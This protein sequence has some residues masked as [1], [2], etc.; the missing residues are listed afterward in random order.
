VHH[1]S[2]RLLP[3]LAALALTL[4]ACDD[5]AGAAARAAAQARADS[6]RTAATDGG[7]AVDSALPIPE[8]L[9]RLKAA[10]A[11]STD[12][13]RTP[14]RSIDALVARW[15]AAVAGADT[16]TLRALQLDQVEFAYLMYEHHPISR[17]PYEMPP[18]LMWF[19]MTKETNRGAARVLERFGGRPFRITRTVCAPDPERLGPVTLHKGCRVWVAT[20]GERLP[21]AELFGSIVE[22]DRR[23]KFLTY[24]N[25]L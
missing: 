1:L 5:P 23:F 18:A 12:T 20:A 10:L 4:A 3:P 25:D 2:R 14:A 6:G 19:E 24:N 7:T 17:P 8:H 13:L 22:H 21:E 9:R 15:A 11:D 16:A